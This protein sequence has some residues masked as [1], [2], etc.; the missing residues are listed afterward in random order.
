M[1]E[2]IM[3]HGWDIPRQVAN[4]RSDIPYADYGNS[5]PGC[6]D[7]GCYARYYAAPASAEELRSY[8]EDSYQDRVSRADLIRGMTY[9]GRPIGWRRIIA[10]RAHG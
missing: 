5:E 2:P 3:H 8:I 7:M 10:V 6:G 4:G 1:H 9:L